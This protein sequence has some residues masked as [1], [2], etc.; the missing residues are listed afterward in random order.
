MMRPVRLTGVA[1]LDLPVVAEQHGADAV[2][3]EVQ[4]DAEHAVRELEHLAGH[5][6][7]D[8]VYARDA[9]AERHDGADFGDVDID[10]VA[11][12]LVADDLGDLFG[13]DV[14]VDL[15]LLRKRRGCPAARV[16]PVSDFRQP[17]RPRCRRTPC[18]RCA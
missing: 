14:H 16:E 15:F 2:F 8:A 5:G 7:L 11:A 1:F 12:D 18:C 4:R 3:F 6:A 13:F 10:G 9:V 17:C